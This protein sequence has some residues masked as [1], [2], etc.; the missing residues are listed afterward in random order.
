MNNDCI[1]LKAQVKSPKGNLP[2]I[3]M[4]QLKGM[5]IFSAK[6]HGKLLVYFM[7]RSFSLTLG[8]S[9]AAK[10]VVRWGRGRRK[11]GGGGW[12]LGWGVGRGWVLG[13]GVRRSLGNFTFAHT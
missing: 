11:G 7:Q 9:G 10:E 4:K 3:L 5:V 1:I 13:V 6:L 2:H 8:R 12:E